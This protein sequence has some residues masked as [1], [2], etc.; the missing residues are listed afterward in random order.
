MVG[1]SG[2]L[3]DEGDFLGG[4]LLALGKDAELHV[5]VDV[6]G[7]ARESVAELEVSG[8]GGGGGL[9][10]ELE[11]SRI[12]VLTDDG[13]VGAVLAGYAV[14]GGDELGGVASGA[15][16][17]ECDEL[18]LIDGEA[19]DGVGEEADVSDGDAD[20]RISDV[21]GGAGKLDARNVRIVVVHGAVESSDGDVVGRAELDD[22]TNTG[23]GGVAVG[24]GVG[25]EVDRRLCN[26]D[27]RIDAERDALGLALDDGERI[28]GV[29]HDE[30]DVGL[31]E[32]VQVVELVADVDVVVAL[33]DVNADGVVVGEADVG[34]DA[35]GGAVGASDDLDLV[36][37]D[38]VTGEGE[39]GVLRNATN[40]GLER[41]HGGNVALDEGEVLD[42]DGLGKGDGEAQVLLASELG[43]IDGQGA[44][45][46]SL[47]SAGLSSLSAVAVA[48]VGGLDE[49]EL[50]VEGVGEEV[51]LEG[52]GHGLAGVAVDEDVLG[53]GGGVVE[54]QRNDG[55]LEVV[56]GSPAEEVV[57]VAELVGG[58]LVE[59]VG[60]DRGLD[61]LALDGGHDGQGGVAVSVD[62]HELDDV[63]VVLVQSN[64]ADGELLVLETAGTTHV[65]V[66]NA[67]GLDPRAEGKGVDGG[68]AELVAGED[69]ELKTG[70]SVADVEGLVAFRNLDGGAGGLIEHVGGNDGAVA[71]VALD[72][73]DLVS[74][75]NAVTGEAEDGVFVL[76]DEG[77][78]GHG[79][80]VDENV[81]DEQEGHR[82]VA[83]GDELVLDLVVG[84]EFVAQDQAVGV[85][86]V[87]DIE[88]TLAFGVD[89]GGDQVV[90]GL[91]AVGAGKNELGV[92]AG[93]DVDATE[94][95][96]DEV[97]GVDG[98]VVHELVVVDVVEL[99]GG[100]GH[101]S[102]LPLV[103]ELDADLVDVLH[104]VVEGVGDLG[105]GGAEGNDAL[106]VLGGLGARRAGLDEGE[107]VGLSDVVEGADEGDGLSDGRSGWSDDDDSG[108]DAVAGG[109]VEAGDGDGE[110]GDDSHI[111]EG[112]VAEE[113][114]ADT[115][116]ALAHELDAF[117]GLVLND[118]NGSV[119]LLGGLAGVG[120]GQ[121]E[122]VVVGEKDAGDA[123]VLGMDGAVVAE[124]EV[125]DPVGRIDGEKVLDGENG[126]VHGVDGRKAEELVAGLVLDAGVRKVDERGGGVLGVD[127]VVGGVGEEGAGQVLA[128][129]T[130]L[131][132]GAQSDALDGDGGAHAS[133]DECAVNA[134]D[135]DNTEGREQ[136]VVLI[137]VA[138][139][140][141]E[142]SGDGLEGDVDV[143]LAV[144]VVDF[145]LGN[146]L[147]AVG[148]GELDAVQR[149]GV[150]AG[151]DEAGRFVG[152]DDGG[153]VDDGLDV[154][155]NGELVVDGVGSLVV[156]ELDA[157][158]AHILGGGDVGDG[159]VALDGERSILD[160]IALGLGGGEGDG[161]VLGE[162]GVQEEDA[163]DDVLAE[164]LRKD[165]VD[166]RDTDSE[167][168][169][170][171]VGDELGVAVLVAELPG[172]A[173]LRE[174][175]AGGLVDDADFL[176]IIEAVVQG[177]L[178]VVAGLLSIARV[179]A[180]TVERVGL[181]SVDVD[182]EG[183]VVGRG[184][185]SHVVDV[186]AEGHVLEGRLVGLQG[187]RGSTGG[188]GE[189]V[190]EVDLAGG[191][192][193]VR[194]VEGKEDL[195]VLE[196]V[197]L[198]NSDFTAVVIDELDAIGL[199][200]DSVAAE[201]KEGTV[202]SADDDVGGLL[203]DN[204]VVDGDRNV[205]ETESI[206]TELE[207]RIDVRHGGEGDGNRRLADVD[208]NRLDVGGQDALGVRNEEDLSVLRDGLGGEGE[209]MDIDREVL[210][211]SEDDL[212]V[213]G[214]SQLGEIKSQW[215][216]LLVNSKAVGDLALF[217]SNNDVNL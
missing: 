161:I 142:R 18:I 50:V 16:L 112:L 187:E 137:A 180:N 14:H 43:G 212:Q 102:L 138:V 213:S 81:V 156:L 96:V 5:V 210:G 34:G 205:V 24:G 9:E 22:L 36:A 196:S 4:E 58:S 33:V 188:G 94:G 122:L 30:G 63:A 46:R 3:D 92:V 204:S 131:V 74:G 110:V 80:V 170:S 214:V 169:G 37:L 82:E 127:A 68:D 215:S 62:G 140:D 61:A 209:R 165:G 73:L 107:V 64:T 42:E 104:G 77:E 57:A 60:G 6:L 109:D 54:G 185:V 121:L 86:D 111:V 119:G 207:A 152:E 56:V 173:G 200:V 155:L 191:L 190:A 108:V 176:V 149:S 195:V 141:M 97:V 28:D 192:D 203:I 150:G 100:N 101:G 38:D 66:R 175:V 71:V 201:G 27:G 179:E 51:A 2:L 154:Q 95:D 130:D 181:L 26:A 47:R 120:E 84:L 88:G 183:V 211:G 69:V 70:E 7:R 167:V 21:V 103:V 40:E 132:V 67:D 160:G 106:V 145:V 182:G 198:T 75:S 146:V 136:F 126:V 55:H 85:V 29:E 147:A 76:K 151:E 194:G 83:V 115:V 91:V 1:A 49:S 65:L 59:D 10:V 79:V 134:G 89:E 202:R 12:G 168:V 25:N 208:G 133:D 159:D 139:A 11:L 163:G 174:G 99:L 93:L 162:G 19:K 48:V 186:H 52:E 158:A 39:G 117:H 90:V 172:K 78:G 177:E 216:R 193:A 123:D 23:D 125:G 189:A 197:T 113:L 148:G 8:G 128:D 166:L 129:P 32:G 199:G 20:T 124:G 45:V 153:A 135:A 105:A 17:R 98:D 178:D 44:G 144:H 157:D 171:V 15:L 114:V 184:D 13:K 164:G 116:G 143:E 206:G 217:H 118:G 72:E 41:R 31:D 35:L 53:I 87:S